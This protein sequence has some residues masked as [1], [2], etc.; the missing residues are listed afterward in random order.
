LVLIWPYCLFIYFIELCQNMESIQRG[1]F[2]SFFTFSFQIMHFTFCFI[3]FCPI[4]SSILRRCWI[5]WMRI[6]KR[7]LWR[8]ILTILNS[9]WYCCF[10]NLMYSSS[11]ICAHL[12]S[13]TELSLT[14]KWRYGCPWISI[15]GG[16]HLYI[17]TFYPMFLLK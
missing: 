3:W 16:N 14:T 17:D 6:A 4:N 2:Y 9:S 11:W 1:N 12:C 15:R 10:A 7:D 8:G 5:Y 13:G